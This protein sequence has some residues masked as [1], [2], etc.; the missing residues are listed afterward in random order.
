MIAELAGQPEAGIVAPLACVCDQVQRSREQGFRDG[1]GRLCLCTF[2]R[3]LCLR[4]R[5]KQ[6][7][8]DA[9][10]FGEPG[11]VFEDGVT[12]PDIRP[13]RIAATKGGIPPFAANIEAGKAPKERDL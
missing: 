6:P 10:I 13:V 8:Q 1:F 12:L 3:S 5:V 2:L 11:A 7:Q 9:Q 4:G